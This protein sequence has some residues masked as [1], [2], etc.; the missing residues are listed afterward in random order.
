MTFFEIIKRGSGAAVTG[1]IDVSNCTTFKEQLYNY[2]ESSNADVIMDFKDLAYIDS[3]GLGILVGAY[4]R[5][6]QKELKLSIINMND[7]IRKLFTIT[8][9]DT[10]ID[11]G[12]E[13]K[14]V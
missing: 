6:K 4:K 13:E 14:R 7:N 3:A 12:T 10:L 8:K 5:L 1:E 11:T 9:L 2:I